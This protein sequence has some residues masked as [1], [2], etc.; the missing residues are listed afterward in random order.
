MFMGFVSINISSAIIKVATNQ[1]AFPVRMDIKTSVK[2]MSSC[3]MAFG[4][5]KI[6]VKMKYGMTNF[7]SMVVNL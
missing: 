3:T 6:I 4:M 5:A 7:R 1:E 2:D